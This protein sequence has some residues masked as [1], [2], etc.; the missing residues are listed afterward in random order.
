MAGEIEHPQHELRPTPCSFGEDRPYPHRQPRDLW[1]AKDP[2]RAEGTRS[3]V[4][5]EA[6]CEADARSWLVWVWW[7]QEEGPHYTPLTHRGH[8]SCSRSREA[9]LHSGGSRS[10]LGSRHHLRENLGRLA[11][12]LVCP[13]HLF[14]K[15]RRM[16]YG[17]P[18]QDGAGT[19][20]FEYGYLQPPSRCWSDP[21]LG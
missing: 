4:R 12:P 8:P 13:G 20:R 1:G 21:P 3:K 17:Q 9:Q 10:P 2:L 7:S 6:R 5:Q 15:D 18:S 16:V 14:S 19:R 11:L